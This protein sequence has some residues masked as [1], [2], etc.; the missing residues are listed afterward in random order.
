MNKNNLLKYLILL[1]IIPQILYSGEPGDEIPGEIKEVEKKVVEKKVELE[2]LDK[3]TIDTKTIEKLIEK[4]L[5]PKTTTVDLPKNRL[6]HMFGQA[7]LEKINNQNIKIIKNCQPLSNVEKCYVVDPKKKSKHFNTYY[8]YTNIDNK[9]NAII[10][11]DKKKL[12]DVSKCKE[13][14][15]EWVVF[16]ENFDLKKTTSENKNLSVIYS[17]KPQQKPLEIFSNCY[18]ESFRDVESSFILKFFK[19]A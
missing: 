12:T 8:F 14:M 15:D 7:F 5:E 13:K 3:E 16:L 11:F 4:S 18:S 10:A 1:I 6:T 9:V 17:D 19:Q 2:V